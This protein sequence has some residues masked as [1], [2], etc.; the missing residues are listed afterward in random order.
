LICSNARSYN[1]WKAI[2]TLETQEFM[3]RKNIADKPAAVSEGSASA[4]A[5]PKKPRAPRATSTAAAHKHKKAL[6]ATPEPT[7][8][9]T[10][11]EASAIPAVAPEA[12]LVEP[13]G[14]THEQ[15][16][17]RAYLIAEARGFAGGSPADDWFQAERQLRGELLGRA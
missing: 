15:I 6:T 8:E 10:A 16:A 17:V 12:V 14:P 3:K 5:T 2:P 9:T 4:A 13:A 7:P 11:V 1:Q